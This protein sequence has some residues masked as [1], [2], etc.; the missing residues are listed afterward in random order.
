[1]PEKIPMTVSAIHIS[2]LTAEHTALSI[3][4]H[5]TRYSHLPGPV[6]WIW[7]PQ[8]REPLLSQSQIRSIGERS[9]RD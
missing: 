2:T 8:A 1:M 4:G 6:L 5:S 3:P 9:S 7:H